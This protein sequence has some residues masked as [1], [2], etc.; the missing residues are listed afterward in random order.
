MSLVFLLFKV[1]E[2]ETYREI[3]RSH[4]ISNGAEWLLVA[5]RDGTM[6]TEKDVAGAVAVAIF[7]LES[8]DPKAELGTW[9]VGSEKERLNIID[10]LEGCERS[11]LKFYTKRTPCSCLVDLYTS[12]RTKSK[13]GLCFHCKQRFDRSKLL[14]CAS[15]KNQ[16]FCSRKCQLENW[17]SHKE[18]C[19]L[20]VELKENVERNAWILKQDA[21]HLF[22]Y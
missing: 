18:L 15:C 1:W 14:V 8:Y 12:A 3:A 20:E 22:W 7:A 13:T 6:N 9:S 5:K 19:K 2:N 10:V 4:L 21:R 17:P 16:Q 11:T